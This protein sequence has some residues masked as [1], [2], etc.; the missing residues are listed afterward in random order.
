MKGLEQA[1]KDLGIP[2]IDDLVNE[3]EKKQ[4]EAELKKQA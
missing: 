1:L 2:L 3:E 4:I